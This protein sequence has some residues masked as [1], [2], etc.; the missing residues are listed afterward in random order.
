[1]RLLSLH[2]TR[3]HTELQNR[4]AGRSKAEKKSLDFADCCEE[5]HLFT[6]LVWHQKVAVWISASAKHIE[7]FSVPVELL[8]FADEFL[9]C[10]RFVHAV[11]S[12][13]R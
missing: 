10:I 8:I 1:M 12:S 6:G 7:D 9:I 5:Q 11:A 3:R 13:L 4:M 2:L